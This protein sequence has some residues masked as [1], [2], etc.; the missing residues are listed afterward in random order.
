MPTLTFSVQPDGLLVDVMIGMDAAGCQYL[1]QSGRPI[2]RSVLV[3]GI[4]DT[5][6]DATAVAPRALQALGLPL[7]GSAQTATAGGLMNVGVYE[8]SLS[9][10]PATGT[11]TMFTAPRLVVTELI[12][13][14]PGIEVLVGLDVILQGIF[15]V[16]G[17]GRVFSFTF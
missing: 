10:L 1:Q 17:P 5:A 11:A 4:M 3:R 6:A 13:A 7:Y 15:N 9:I 8:I 2:P 12:H 16:D 14:A